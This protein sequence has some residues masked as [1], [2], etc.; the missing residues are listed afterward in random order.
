MPAFLP[1]TLLA[2]CILAAASGTARA[3]DELH[4]QLPAAGR[5]SALFGDSRSKAQVK[6][7]LLLGV[8]HERT[9][10][11]PNGNLRVFRTKTYHRV[12]HP[13]TGKVVRLPDRWR[14]RTSLLLSPALRL[15]R[16]KTT[17]DFHKSV[18]EALGYPFSEE[19]E[20]YF[21][22]DEARVTATRDGRRLTR[23][24]L[25]R[26]E[27]V[28]SETYDYERDDVPLEIIGMLISVA[29][30][31]KVDR[32]DFDLLVPGGATHEV[33]AETHRVRDASRF[34]DGYPVPRGALKPSGDKAVVVMRLSSPVKYLIF[35]HKFYLVYDATE[36]SKALGLWG[37]DPDE[38]LQAFRAE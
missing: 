11:L 2:L 26:G 33:Q 31:Q 5:W 17:L 25:L 34:T 4:E 32:F 36:P 6:D 1:R 27:V 12:K 19:L 37:G 23:K 18:A 7:G 29:V 13:E 24:L 38:H 8:G 15:I 14:V 20:R 3:H 22:W 35:P 16:G 28:E 30:D 9:E 21:E 10:L